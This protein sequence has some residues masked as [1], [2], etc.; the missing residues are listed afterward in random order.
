MWVWVVSQH[1]RF[2]WTVTDGWRPALRRSKWDM[3]GIMKEFAEKGLPS[4]ALRFFNVYGPRQDPVGDPAL[5]PTDQ[6]S[7][8]CLV[9]GYSRGS[10]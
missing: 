7:V 1:Q 3:E 5:L 8:W 6:R 9:L 2:V 10:I 4:T